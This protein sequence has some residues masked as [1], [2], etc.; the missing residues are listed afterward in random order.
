MAQRFNARGF[1]LRFLFALILVFATFNPSGF[2]YY[3]WASDIIAD[4]S[5]FLTPPFALITI[6]LLIGW[7]IYLRATLRSLGGFGL[8][9]SFAFFAIIIW[10]LVDLGLLSIDKFSGLTYIVLFLTAAV[11]SVGMS[12]SH[13]RRRLSGQAD[14]DDVDE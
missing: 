2:S 11:L 9:L 8:L 13:I 4:S 10:W 12:W 5:V 7:T 1:W 14:M 6:I 3:H